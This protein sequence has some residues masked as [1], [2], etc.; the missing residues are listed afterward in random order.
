MSSD[1]VVGNGVFD[2][3]NEAVSALVVLGYSPQE[4]KCAVAAVD[5]TLELEEVIKE[6]LKKLMR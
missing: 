3:G 1:D 2:S 6:A 4:A 5:P